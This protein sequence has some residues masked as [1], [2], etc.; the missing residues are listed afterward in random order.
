MIYQSDDFIQYQQG[1]VI[2]EFASCFG[3]P[4]IDILNS[5]TDRPK[6]DTM[7]NFYKREEF[8]R[9]Y[10]TIPL[11]RENLFLMIRPD[12]NLNENGVHSISEYFIKT[13]YGMHPT[14][15]NVNYYF[16]GTNKLDFSDYSERTKTLNV[17]WN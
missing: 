2:I 5:V 14:I 13:R 12:P 17:S 16:Q 6:Y 10:Y 8:G 7:G 3:N 15:K 4:K 9:T 11:P 1:Y